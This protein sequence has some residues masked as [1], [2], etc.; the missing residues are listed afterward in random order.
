MA[1]SRGRAMAPEAIYRLLERG[2]ASPPVYQ[3]QYDPRALF[4]A[5]KVFISG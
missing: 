2:P 3:G 1:A 4:A 5:L